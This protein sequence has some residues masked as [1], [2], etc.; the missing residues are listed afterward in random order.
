MIKILLDEKGS[1][2]IENALWIALFVLVV[3]VAVKSLAS[4]TTDAIGEMIQK[5]SNN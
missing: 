3:A 4:A 1:T 5:I 2:F